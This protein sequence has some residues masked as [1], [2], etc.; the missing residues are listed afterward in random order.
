MISTLARNPNA[1]GKGEVESSIPSGS[2]ITKARGRGALLPPRFFRWTTRRRQRGISAVHI[3][4]RTML[5]LFSVVAGLFPLRP[6]RV[7]TMLQRNFAQTL[8]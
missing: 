7:N 8:S 3:S 4:Q 2:T 6:D 5:R 1:L